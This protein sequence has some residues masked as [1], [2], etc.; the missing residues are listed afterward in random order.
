[1]DDR[2]YPPQ[3]SL[4]IGL[5]SR[6]PRCGEGKL[7]T[8]FLTVPPKCDVCGLDYSF[9]DAG[10]GPA[11][12]IMMIAGFIIVGLALYVEVAYQP[13][14]WVHAV[15]WIPLTLFLT[16]GMLRPLKGWLIAQQF[17]HK[18]Q[19]GRLEE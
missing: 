8:G 7:F 13:P 12:F 14:Y 19:P 18:A 15:L 10:D 3:S 9:A 16:V 11:V 1:M 5:K 4:K 2:Y 17:R 6:C